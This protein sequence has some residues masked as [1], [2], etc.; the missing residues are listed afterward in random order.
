MNFRIRHKTFRFYDTA[1]EKE[2]N[3]GLKL[4]NY[5]KLRKYHKI[6]IMNDDDDATMIAG[7]LISL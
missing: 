1:K 5:I 7:S 3:K 4:A 6:T 2:Q